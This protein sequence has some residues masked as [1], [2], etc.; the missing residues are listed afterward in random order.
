M[1]AKDTT[2]CVCGKQAYAFYPVIDPDIPALPYCEKCLRKQQKQV[3][4]ALFGEEEAEKF[5]NK[6]K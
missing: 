4:A 5:M 1:L 2:C 3:I 6:F